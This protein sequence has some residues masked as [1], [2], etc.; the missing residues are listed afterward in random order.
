[1][2]PIYQPDSGEGSIDGRKKRIEEEKSGKNRRKKEISKET[3]QKN[4]DQCPQEA[5]EKNS[6]ESN[7]KTDPEGSTACIQKNSSSKTGRIVCS[8]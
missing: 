4:L 7:K 6:Q 5:G 8:S 2:G 3:G 1:M